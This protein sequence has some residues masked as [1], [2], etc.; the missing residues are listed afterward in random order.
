[1]YS[2]P[3]AQSSSGMATATM[4]GA[5]M[6]FSH[7]ESGDSSSVSISPASQITHLE[8]EYGQILDGRSG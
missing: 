4:A 7:D 8:L 3:I 2:M 6:Y 1:M 5:H